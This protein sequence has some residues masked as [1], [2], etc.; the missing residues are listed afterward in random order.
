MRPAPIPPGPS[1]ESVWD[2][3]RP[4]RLEDTDKHIR[5]I[6]NDVLIAET[7]YAKRIL[8][9]SHPPNY[10]IPLKDIRSEYLLPST[11]ATFCEWKGRAHYYTLRVGDREAKNVAWCYPEITPAY[12]ELKEHFGFYPGPMDAC[13]VDH[14]KVKP[15]AGI[16]Y[17]GWVTSDIVGPFKG[18]A[19]TRGW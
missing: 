14:E 16:F 1:Q 11:H 6:F 17:A 5:I 8:E 18:D 3:P 7:R 19:G 15:Q 4:P 13:Y 10:Y 2:Y 9:T 12:A